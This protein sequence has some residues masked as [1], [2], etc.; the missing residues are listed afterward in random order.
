[1]EWEKVT[2]YT[3]HGREERGRE[4]KGRRKTGGKGEL[5][6]RRVRNGQV[7]RKGEVHGGGEE[8]EQG[9]CHNETSCFVRVDTKTDLSHAG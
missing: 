9:I 5:F 6:F 7:Q 8:Q 1:M 2:G 4:E 3:L